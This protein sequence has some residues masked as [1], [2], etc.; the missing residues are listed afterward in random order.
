MAANARPE[1]VTALLEIAGVAP[2]S[3]R[4]D[5]AAAW[6]VTQLQGVQPAFDALAFEDEPAGFVLTLDRQAQ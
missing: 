5:A 6:L 4:P 1:L 3:A 2:Q